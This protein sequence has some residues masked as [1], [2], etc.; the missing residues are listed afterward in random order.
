MTQKQTL[1]DH[2]NRGLSISPLE[3][4]GCYGVYRLAARIKDLRDEGHQIV[5][6]MHKDQRGKDYARYR[7]AA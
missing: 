7:L 3:A 1:L 6:E 2:L 5:T 4:F